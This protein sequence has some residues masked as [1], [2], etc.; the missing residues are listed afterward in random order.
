MQPDQPPQENNPDWLVPP[1]PPTDYLEQGPAKKPTRRR[2]LA[3]SIGL[4]AVGALAGAIAVSAL[5]SNTSPQA[6]AADLPASNGTTGTRPGLPGGLTP[7]G[8]FQNGGQ[9]FRGGGLAGEQR[10]Q[11]TLTRVDGSTVTVRTSSGTASY[12]VTGS[13]QI[14][15]NGAPA[16]V[17]QLRPGD[18]VFL[19]VYPS[20]SG[21]RMLVERIFAGTFPAYGGGGP[22]FGGRDGDR[23]G[24]AGTGTGQAHV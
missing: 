10:L 7:D 4:L 20:G 21:G 18:P 17:S 14:I 6:T 5:N 8:G 24:D 23:G 19:H 2:T 3:V 13:T 15:R 1:A 11:G 16:T 9:G 22:G 12:T